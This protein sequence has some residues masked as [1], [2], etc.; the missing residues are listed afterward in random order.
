MER[1]N[2]IL[3]KSSSLR[4]QYDCDICQDVGWVEVSDGYKPCKC[5]ETKRYKEIL[6][7]SGISEVFL[8]KNFDNYVPRNKSQEKAKKTA[9]QYVKD[10]RKVK[11]QRNNS[12]AFLAQVGAG[13][14]HLSIA[15]S[16]KLMESGIGVL[17][18]PYREV[19]TALKQNMIDE[20]YYQREI[21][22]YKNA[23]VLLIDDLFKGR[24]TES[25]INIMYEIINFRYL[26][27]KPIILSCEYRV[28]KL[29]DF[30]EAIGSR[31]IEMCKGR[32]TE[33]QGKELNYRLF[34]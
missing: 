24:I 14:T 9:M 21:G 18:M 2:G 17:Y 3:A 33:F 25:D 19:V 6:F 32:I 22:R 4:V 31:I 23:P 30:D 1:V 12:I 29:L 15:V 20:E 34:D 10:F 26:K 5:Q 27:A 13:K 28:D 8:K 7:K 11:N 16:N